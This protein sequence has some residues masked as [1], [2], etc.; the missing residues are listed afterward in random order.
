VN[1]SGALSETVLLAN[2]AYRSGGGFDWD[3]TAFKSN[4]N[5]KVDQYINAEFAKGWEV[6]EI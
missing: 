4:G 6:D 2:A 1:Y 5:A 3:A